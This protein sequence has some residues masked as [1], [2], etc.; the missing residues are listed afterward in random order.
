[1]RQMDVVSGL[2]NVLAGPCFSGR[3]DEGVHKSGLDICSVSKTGVT[4]V[5]SPSFHRRL[6]SRMIRPSI[7]DMKV[8][9]ALFPTR[10]HK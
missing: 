8:S 3:A 9:R 5:W 6:Y 4:L 7:S 1:M 2:I 10:I